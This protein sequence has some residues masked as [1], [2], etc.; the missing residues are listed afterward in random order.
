MGQWQRGVRGSFQ[1]C[2]EDDVAQRPKGTALELRNI[3]SVHQTKAR[4]QSPQMA[5]VAVRSYQGRGGRAVQPNA[6]S[7]SFHQLEDRSVIAGQ[8]RIAEEGIRAPAQIARCRCANVEGKDCW[9]V[10]Q[11][12]DELKT[13]VQSKRAQDAKTIPKAG[14]ESQNQRVT[15]KGA[16]ELSKIGG[17]EVDNE[18]VQVVQLQMQVKVGRR[19]FKGEG[20]PCEAMH[21]QQAKR[22]QH[23][24]SKLSKGER[25]DKNVGG[26]QHQW[27]AVRYADEM[28]SSG[29]VIWQ[30]KGETSVVELHRATASSSESGNNTDPTGTANHTS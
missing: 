8:T 26:S 7:Q 15:I 21:P 27:T 25:I 18:K 11:R 6:A 24:Q 20:K 5:V 29:E 22:V 12:E 28:A 13:L 9:P 3:D 14:N 4:E 2:T 19:E 17:C 1:G 23:G 30:L 16:T 10:T